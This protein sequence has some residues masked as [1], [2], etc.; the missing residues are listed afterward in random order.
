MK[1]YSSCRVCNII[2]TYLLLAVG[3][4]IF[5]PIFAKTHSLTIPVTPMQVSGLLMI[6]GLGLFIKR[7]RDTYSQSDT[8]QD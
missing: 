3:I 2:R 5:L 6:I 7:Y 4:I 8:D 1:I